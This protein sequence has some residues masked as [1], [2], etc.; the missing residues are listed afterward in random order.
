[1]MIFLI[2]AVVTVLGVNWSLHRTGITM[3]ADYTCGYQEHEHDVSCYEQVLICTEKDE[4]HEHN[5]S[6]YEQR[7]IC[8]IPEHNHTEGCLLMEQDEVMEETETVNV[9]EDVTVIDV[10]IDVNTESETEGSNSETEDVTDDQNDMIE[11]TIIDETQES[12]VFSDG[13]VLTGEISSEESELK[14][15]IS[16]ENLD[17]S[18]YVTK[19]TGSGTKYDASGRLYSSELRMDFCYAAEDIQSTNYYYEYPSGIIIPDGLLN[20]KKY[21]LYDSGG[22]KAGIYYFEKTEEGRYRVRI[23]FD[24]EYIDQNKGEIKGNIQFSGQIAESSADDAGNIVIAGKD[25]VTLE[26]PNDKIEYPDDTT[27]RYD[28]KT[29]KDGTY[30]IQDGKLVYTVYVYSVKGTPGEIE[31]KDTITATGMQLGTPQVTVTKEIV[32]RYYNSNKKDNW[33]DVKKDE[34]GEVSVE[35][36]Y[37]DGTLKL[38]LPQIEPAMDQTT[39]SNYPVE[40]YTRYKLVYTYDVS[41]LTQEQPVANNM[42][43][44]NSKNNTTEVKSNAECTVKINNQHTLDKTGSFDEDTNQISWALKINKNGLNI[45]GSKLTDKMLANLADGTNV[46]ISPDNGYVLERSEDGKI[47]GIS[48]VALE[49]GENHNVYTIHYQTTVQGTWNNQT[50]S[51]EA[52]FEPGDGSA[53][54]DK[55]TSVTVSGGTIE[56]KAGT[57]IISEDAATLTIPWTVI[58]GIPEGGFKTGTVITDNFPQ[59]NGD[60]YMTRDQVI[61]WLQYNTKWIYDGYETNVALTDESVTTILFQAS[62]GNEY[63]FQDIRSYAEAIRGLTFTGYKITFNQ[64]MD[65]PYGASKLR[66]SYETTVDISNANLGSNYYKNK[67]SVGDKIAEATY[68]YKKGGVIKTDENGKTDTTQKENADGTLIW[69]VSVALA[70]NSDELIITDTL[71]EGVTLA[72]IQGADWISSVNNLTIE[73]DGKIVGSS[74]DYVI[75][76]NYENNVVTLRITRANHLKLESG[77]R[78]YSFIFKC[79]TEKDNLVDYEIGKTYSFTNKVEAKDNQG[80]LGNAEQTQEWTEKKETKVTK[81]IDKSGEWNNT[82]RRVHYS[83][84]VN[85]DGSDLVEGVDVLTL[86]DVFTYYNLQYAYPEGVYSGTGTPYYVNA[87]LVPASVKVYQAEI[88]ADGSLEKGEEISNLAWKVKTE[89]GKDDAIGGSYDTSTLTIENL[90]DGIPMI[91]EYDYQFQTD[92]PEDYHTMSMMQVKNS[93]ELEGT[94]YKDDKTQGDVKWD[95]QETSGEVSAEKIYLLYKVSKGNFGDTLQGAVFKLQKYNG[96]DYEDTDTTYTTDADGKIRIRWQK[97][98]SDVQYEKNTLYRLVETQA[99][100]G[101]ALPDSVEDTAVYFYFSDTED[102]EHTLPDNIPDTAVNLTKESSVFYAENEKATTDITIQKQW[103]KQNGEP[104]AGHKGSI[105]VDVYRKESTL[106]SGNNEKSTL[107]GVINIGS[108]E[109]WATAWQTISSETHPKGTKITFSLATTSQWESAPTVLL[110]G[111]ALDPTTR[112][113][114]G[115]NSLYTYSFAMTANENVILGAISWNSSVWTFSD[116]TAEEPKVET[117][118]ESA[119]EYYGTYTITAEENWTKIISDLPKTGTNTEGKKISYVYYI[120][121][122]TNGNYDTSYENNGGISSGTITV[123]NKM[124]ENP[125]YLLPETGGIGTIWFTAVGMT[126]MSAALMYGQFLWRRR[127]RSK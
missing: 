116:I 53:E 76:G 26:I 99:P 84:K 124:T 86:K 1:M 31:F 46:T 19:L 103:L 93:A 125:S 17:M 35:T 50:V 43:N 85:P 109:T 13:E 23:E 15:S 121:E 87:W 59:N 114:N 67:I 49:N 11:D 32:T 97:S 30:S 75:N 64:D 39:D 108:T 70:E 73:E 16:E 119:G 44:V 78:Y 34:L 63:T 77:T 107:N 81:V 120:K 38:N 100:K 4:V 68:E 96:T 57:G 55:T 42:V 72:S 127:G 110:N 14:R 111:S 94:G 3:T 104:D 62:D 112:A 20:G 36:S 117:P 82:N 29:K 47:T 52:K 91:L 126:L 83:I 45:A 106:A 101:Y 6:C 27:N 118:S 113:W 58:M 21:D 9:T 10:P 7:M 115:E 122:L 66:F 80:S 98:S 92:I 60:Q 40:E 5:D 28:I 18:T 22:K 102:T 65:A 33:N 51:N 12:E 54:I 90:P 95:K 48:F 25:N 8:S 74:S 79:K 41:N 69:K 123:T 2:L 24:E 56:K 105:Q 71:P 37:T 61:N 89:K 88:K